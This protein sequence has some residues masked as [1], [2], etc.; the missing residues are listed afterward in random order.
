MTVKLSPWNVQVGENQV[1]KYQSLQCNI[2]SMGGH[3]ESHEF[4]GQC[5]EIVS[6]NLSILSFSVSNGIIA[7]AL[8]RT[9]ISKQNQKSHQSHPEI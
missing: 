3:W 2:S 6:S 8:Q 7:R 4:D 1:T 5:V 9:Q